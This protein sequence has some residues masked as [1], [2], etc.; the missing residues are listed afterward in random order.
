VSRS[1]IIGGLLLLLCVVFATTLF[2]KMLIR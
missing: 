1:D 2:E